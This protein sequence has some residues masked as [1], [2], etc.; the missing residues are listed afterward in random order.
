MIDPIGDEGSPSCGGPGIEFGTYTWAAATGTL[1]LT[2]ITIDTNGCAGLN[3]P[4]S[5]TVLFGPGDHSAT[6]IEIA[7]DGSTMAIPG[8]DG[9]FV[10]LRVS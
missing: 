8:S 3:E 1:T 5:P 7:P 2:N 4:P 10:L 9:V 6:G